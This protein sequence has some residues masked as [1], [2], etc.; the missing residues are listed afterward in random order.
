MTSTAP[1]SRDCAVVELRQYTLHPGRR[2]A[3]V[4]LFDRAFVES[5]EAVG[6]RVIGQFRDARDPNRFVWLRGFADL[7]SRAPALQAFYGGPVWA[8]NS[9]AANATMVDSDD[10]LL[11]RPAWPGSGVTV[12]Q[13]RPAAGAVGDAPGVVDTT[14]FS[15]RTPPTPELLDAA[16][17]ANRVLRAGGALDTGWYITEPGP[18]AFPRL[19][20]REG[21]QVLVAVALFACAAD[22]DAFLRSGRWA[23]EA[24]PRLQPHLAAQPQ[25]LRL[26]PTARSALRAH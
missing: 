19:P 13:P 10:V 20:V 2:D 23:S 26:T 25:S 21:V 15:L 12:Q 11:L 18:N 7:G 8:E 22:H 9:R 14:V 24:G 17:S 4:A 16:H 1:A 6:M 5:Q 3:L